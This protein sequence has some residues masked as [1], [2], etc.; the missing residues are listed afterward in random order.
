MLTGFALSELDRRLTQVIR[1]GTVAEIDAENA[2]VRVKLG[3]NTTGGRPWVTCAGTVKVW[4]PPAVGE[5]VV[6][7]SPSG[8]LDQGIVLPS[9]HYNAFAAPS[10]DAQT[11]HA[12]LSDGTHLTWSPSQNALNLDLDATG[13]LE[14]KSGDLSVTVNSREVTFQAPDTSFCFEEGGVRLK[15]LT[16]HIDLNL[17]V[18]RLQT[19][20]ATVTL[21]KEAVHLKGKD[22]ELKL[23]EGT[24]QLTVAGQTL[25]LNAEGLFLNGRPL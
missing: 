22:A 14:L 6:L 13:N 24:A 1:L 17:N 15:Y 4:N 11:V 7:L 19:E 5:Q 8:D 20:D 3:E 2:R 9:L 18:V 23:S 12:Q 21:S 10:H 25:L 16:N